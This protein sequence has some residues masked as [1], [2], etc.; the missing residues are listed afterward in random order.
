MIQLLEKLRVTAASAY[1]SAKKDTL[2]VTHMPRNVY[3][4]VFVV[5]EG[6]PALATT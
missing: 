2:T 6:F 3:S 1:K 4:Y 5:L